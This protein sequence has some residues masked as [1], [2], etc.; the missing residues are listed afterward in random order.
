MA[1]MKNEMTIPETLKWV[2]K[3][4]FYGDFRYRYENIS[5]ETNGAGDD[6]IWGTADDGLNLAAGSVMIDRLTSG[7]SRDITDIA[8]PVS[9]YR[10][11][12]PYDIGAYEYQGP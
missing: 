9:V 1:T 8:R 10:P 12:T 7:Q 4:K 11:G 3:I 5:Q 2:E 6:G